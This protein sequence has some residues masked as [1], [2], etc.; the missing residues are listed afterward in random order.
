MFKSRQNHNIAL[1][2]TSPFCEMDSFKN[3]TL[4]SLISQTYQNFTFYYLDTFY[5][6]N[7]Q[8]FQ[9][10]QD[11]VKFKI[12]HA[13]GLHAT[14]YPHSFTWEQYNS[15]V[16]LSQEPIFLR[17][18]RFR[19]YHPNIVEFVLNTLKPG[20]VLNFPHSCSPIDFNNVREYAITHLTWGGMIA[21]TRDEWISILNGEDEVGLH[22]CHFEDFELVNRIGNNGL[23]LI[24]F[25]NAIHRHDHHKD[26]INQP[27]PFDKPIPPLPYPGELLGYNHELEN[28]LS[29]HPDFEPFIHHGFKWFY[30]KTH[31]ILIPSNFDEYLEWTGDQ[32]QSIIGINNLMMGRNIAKI[33]KDLLGVHTLCERIQ[34]IHDSFTDPIYYQR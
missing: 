22:W 34:W 21:M 8:Y 15:A 17:F 27:I 10:L 25:L 23:R 16:L 3:I 29:S 26:I 18:G 7:Q 9:E 20:H 13:P 19:S 2:C 5:Y 24:S 12:V 1:L 32:R 33:N 28:R 14:H 11:Q 4:P 30:N 6:H 31:N